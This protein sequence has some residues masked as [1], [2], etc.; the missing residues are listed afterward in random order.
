[1]SSYILISATSSDRVP[2]VEVGDPDCPIDIHNYPEAVAWAEAQ[3]WGDP[4]EMIFV[5]KEGEED[6]PAGFP[7]YY[8][9][10]E[11]ASMRVT[12]RGSA[13]GSA[14]RICTD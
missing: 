1:M 13:G 2:G 6:I 3:G 14:V 12:V 11:E 7:T 9:E 8:L 4:D 5:V 10:V